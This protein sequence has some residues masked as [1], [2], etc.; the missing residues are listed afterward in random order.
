MSRSRA[1]SAIE[2][3]CNY[4]SGYL[5]ALAVWQWVA[6]PVFN[7]GTS[8]S[9]G[10]GVTLLFTAVSVIR[11]YVWRRAFNWYHSREVK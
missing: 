5:L 3:T 4:I 7:L 1:W 11:S 9:E 10:V 6:V 8:A 2:I